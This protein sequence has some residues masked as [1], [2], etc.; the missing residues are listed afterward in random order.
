LPPLLT[1]SF[2]AIGPLMMS[3]T[4]PGLVVA[5]IPRRLKSGEAMA[6]VAA[7]ITGRYSG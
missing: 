1:P 4:A 3:H 7:I 5:C 6:A 2:F